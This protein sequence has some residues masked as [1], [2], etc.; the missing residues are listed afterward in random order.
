M[1]VLYHP[2]KSLSKVKKVKGFNPFQR[3]Y[4]LVQSY[5]LLSQINGYEKFMT[6]M[7]VNSRFCF[8]LT[9]CHVK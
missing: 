1:I 4:K 7:L 8:V 9:A 5:F 2:F 3:L 6:F